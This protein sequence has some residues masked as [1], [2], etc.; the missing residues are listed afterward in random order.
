ME[1]RV[2]AKRHRG[3]SKVGERGTR[4][5]GGDILNFIILALFGAF[6]VLPLIYTICQ[7]FKPLE[8]LYKFP[9]DIIVQHPTLDNFK[10]LSIVM[11]ESLVP[12]S[13]YLFNTVFITVVGI[14]GHLIVASMAAYVLEKRRFPGRVIFFKL[15]VTTLLFTASVTAIPNFIVMTRLHW[16]DTYWAVIIPAFGASLGLYLMKQFME[17]IPDSLLEAAKIDGAGEWRIFWKIVMPNVKP[18]WMTLIIFSVQSLW[19]TTGGNYI[20]SEQKKT[21]TYAMNQI[22]AGGVSRAGVG[23]AVG[24]VMLIVPVAVFIVTQSN[25]IQTMATSGMKD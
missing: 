19:G 1:K 25:I 24:L 18:A 23:A 4:S 2:N 15:V 6:M 12:F 17:G 16:V 13:R 22:T 11:S 20:F 9:P 8:E 7:A 3:F 21:L 10:D 5:L 14:A